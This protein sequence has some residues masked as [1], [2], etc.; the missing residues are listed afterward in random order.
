MFSLLRITTAVIKRYAQA[1]SVLLS[2]ALMVIFSYTFVSKTE[3]KNLQTKAK[4][5][6]FYTEANIKAELKEP[7]TLLAGISETLQGMIFDRN[8]ADTVQG[9]IYHINDYVQ[10]ESDKRM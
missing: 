10:E 8:N 1:F 7:E 2:F 4:D 6:I 3:R 9:Y 5:V